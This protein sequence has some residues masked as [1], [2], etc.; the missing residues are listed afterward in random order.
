MGVEWGKA[1]GS[2]AGSLLVVVSTR[3]RARSQGCKCPGLPGFQTAQPALRNKRGGRLVTRFWVCSASAGHVTHAPRPGTTKLQHKL[4]ALPLARSC[5]H[6]PCTMC[7]SSTISFPF[8]PKSQAGNL[9]EEL[10]DHSS[11]LLAAVL[12]YR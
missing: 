8:R 5:F 6:P 4:S 12:R 1:A 11:G 7:I 3:G 2:A 10:K 9:R